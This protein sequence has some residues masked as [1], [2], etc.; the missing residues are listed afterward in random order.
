MNESSARAGPVATWKL[1][2]V[3]A[4]F[5]ITSIAVFAVSH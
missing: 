3:G 1:W 4:A 2:L 5:L